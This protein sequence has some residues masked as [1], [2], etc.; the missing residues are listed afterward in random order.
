MKKIYSLIFL[1]GC[2]AFSCK[3]DNSLLGVDV[4]PEGDAV[5][6]TVS[7]TSTLQLFTIKQDSTRSFN[8]LEKYIGHHMDPYFGQTN[9]TILTRMVIPNNASNISFGE[10]PQVVSAEIVLAVAINGVIGDTAAKL[11][12]KVHQLNSALETSKV[13]Y[14]NFKNYTINSTPVA[15]HTGAIT[16]INGKVYLKIPVSPA[17]AQSIVSNPTYLV[18][19]STFIN[20]YKGLL[21]NAIGTN[22]NPSGN[23]GILLKIDMNNAETGLFVY[24]QNGT[25]ASTKTTLSYRFAFSGEESVRVNTVQYDPFNGGNIFLRKQLAGDSLAGAQNVF[26]KGLGN[27]RIRVKLPYLHK[28]TEK[29]SIAVARALL[30]VK[31]DQGIN[32]TSIPVPPSLALLTMDSTG[33]ELLVTDQLNSNLVS[34]YDGYYNTTNKTYS[35]DISRHIQSILNGKQKNYGFYLV[36]ADPSPFQAIRRDNFGQR[37]ILGG[38][39]HPVYKPEFKL[40][41]VPFNK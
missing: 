31:L 5:N 41:Y 20:T 18:N 33:K 28:Y 12:Y 35:F 3:K 14:T 34:R 22:L 1:I 25:P 30:T 11:T 9:A 17:F 40:T 38:T 26:L 37:L 8:E 23:S 39:Q 27:M 24:Y 32:G 7:D 13:Y 29:Q 6:T 16:I 36:M 2:L 19:N 10:D 4:L 21:I 15:D